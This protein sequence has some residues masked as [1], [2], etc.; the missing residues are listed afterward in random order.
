MFEYEQGHS[1]NKKKQRCK[2][3]MMFS[4]SMQQRKASDQKSDQ[5]HAR[6]KINIIKNVDAE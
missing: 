4:V 5:Y 1:A 2:A 3:M 6:L